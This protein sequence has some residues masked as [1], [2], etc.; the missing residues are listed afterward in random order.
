[1]H[2]FVIRPQAVCAWVQMSPLQ[3]LWPSFPQLV[4]PPLPPRCSVPGGQTQP[5][6][7]QFS[8]PVQAL[9]QRPQLF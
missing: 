6:L 5:P 9:P 7:V 2:S 4:Q 1:M 3:Q 8:P